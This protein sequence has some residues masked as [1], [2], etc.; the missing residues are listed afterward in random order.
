[1][2]NLYSRFSNRHNAP[3]PPGNPASSSTK[4]PRKSKG[5]KQRQE[6]MGRRAPLHKALLLQLQGRESDEMQRGVWRVTCDV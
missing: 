4:L 6:R 3:L 1:L 5:H 2:R